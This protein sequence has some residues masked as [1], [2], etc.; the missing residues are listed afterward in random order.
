M[1]FFTP[2]HYAL[3]MCT[4]AISCY[5]YFAQCHRAFWRLNAKSCCPWVAGWI[6][7][8]RTDALLFLQRNLT[9]TVH[10]IHG[11]QYSTFIAPGSK[12]CVTESDEVYMTVSDDVNLGDWLSA[13]VSGN[14]TDRAVDCR[15]DDEC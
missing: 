2:M 5:V 10:T 6:N 9:S 4:L 1:R 8:I 11:D 14:I 12:H 7:L 3:G 15:A 13:F